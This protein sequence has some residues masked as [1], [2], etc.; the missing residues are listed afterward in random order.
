M[1][2][3]T[4]Y[5]DLYKYTNCTR[6][7]DFYRAH[8]PVQNT[9][10]Y[11]TQTCTENRFVQN[12]DLYRTQICTEHRPV[13]NT[14]VH[15]SDLAEVCTYITGSY[16]YSQQQNNVATGTKTRDG[17]TPREYEMPMPNSVA[18]KRDYERGTVGGDKKHLP[19]RAP[20]PTRRLASSRPL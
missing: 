16:F 3:R 11:R 8:S 6:H 12:T 2:V 17:K 13:Q 14:Y 15:S 18:K 10:L 5:T 9:D 1:Y 19:P 20:P 4:G 7:T